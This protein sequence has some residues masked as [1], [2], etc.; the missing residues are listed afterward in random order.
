[1][2]YPDDDLIFQPGDMERFLKAVLDSTHFQLLQA[3]LCAGSKYFHPEY[4]QDEK[5][6]ARSGSPQRHEAPAASRTPFRAFAS[7]V[8]GCLPDKK[9]WSANS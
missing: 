6:K 8:R 1:M 5:I 7:T 3:S 4:L 2:W 9:K